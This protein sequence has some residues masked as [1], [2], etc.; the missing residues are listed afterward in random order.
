MV[1]YIT[2]IQL[3]RLL[4]MTIFIKKKKKERKENRFFLKAMRVVLN[5]IDIYTFSKDCI[6][7]CSYGLQK[8]L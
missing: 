7:N 6:S 1:T 5:G 2:V 8:P 3:I 4:K